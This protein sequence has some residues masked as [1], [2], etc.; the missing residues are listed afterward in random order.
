MEGVHRK[1]AR[2]VCN[3]YLNLKRDSLE[4]RRIQS[5]LIMVYKII[6][7]LLF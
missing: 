1:A 5:R 6:Q 3:S 7:E 2:F 4:D